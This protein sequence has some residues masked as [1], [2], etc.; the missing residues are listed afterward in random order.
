MA[1]ELVP[2]VVVIK[3]GYP[4]SVTICGSEEEARQVFSKKCRENI[5]NWTKDSIHEID[6]W[7]AEQYNTTVCIAWADKEEKS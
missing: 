3:S 5:D 1:I 6:N 7:W 2:I 4:Y